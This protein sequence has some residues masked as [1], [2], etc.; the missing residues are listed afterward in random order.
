MCGGGGGGGRG[1][2]GTLCH[3][4]FSAIQWI[5]RIRC[6]R[7][8]QLFPIRVDPVSEGLLLPVK[9]TGKLKKLS[10]CVIGM[11]KPV[12]VPVRFSF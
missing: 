1:G 6:P 10:P 2:R 9:Q 11:G 8:S 7:R 4:H 5:E 12:D 3:F